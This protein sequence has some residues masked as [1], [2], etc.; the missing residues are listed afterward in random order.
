[1]L[2]VAFRELAHFIFREFG[3]AMAQSHAT[4]A[5]MQLLQYFRK[6]IEASPTDTESLLSYAVLQM[7]PLHDGLAAEQ[8]LDSIAGNS[9]DKAV[10]AVWYAYCA[11]H[12]LFDDVSLQ[13]AYDKLASSS[14]SNRETQ[15]ANQL[16]FAQ[17]LKALHKHTNDVIR[18]ALRRSIE[19]EPTWVANHQT[20]AWLLE[21]DR[22]YE[23]AVLHLERALQNTIPVDQHWSV[24]RSEF[25]RNITA[26]TSFHVDRRIRDSL[27][28]IESAR[29]S[30][31]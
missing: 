15:A 26:R 4:A 2:S 21:Q 3:G 29:R 13:K 24:V 28:R 10:A 19:L 8:T 11:L 14:T 22:E 17:V 31:I 30:S 5:Q 23:Q 6:S 20:L 12:F 9:E 16:M 1:V 7:D 25:E 27:Q 18:S